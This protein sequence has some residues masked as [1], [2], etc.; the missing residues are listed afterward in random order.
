[1]LCFSKRTLIAG[2]LLLCGSAYAQNYA[3]LD[4]DNQTAGGPQVYGDFPKIVASETQSDSGT[5]EQWSKYDVIGAKSGM[6]YKI[7]PAQ[8]I[9]P[10]LEYH[11]SF[12]P[13]AYLGYLSADPCDIAFGMPFNNTGDATNPG[14]CTVYAGHWLYKAGTRLS[15]SIS[16]T[17]TTLYVAD[18]RNL[19]AGGYAVIYSG[20]P[21]AFV[22]AEHVLIQSVDRSVTPNRVVLAQRGYK[23][24]A[25]AHAANAIIAEHERG[26]G[27][28]NRN[29]AYN[30]STTGPRDANGRT[31]AQVMA[32]WIPGNMN[33][34]SKGQV[35]DVNVTGVY[36]DEDSYVMVNYQADAN[37]DLIIDNGILAN[38]RNVWGEGLDNFYALLRAR[39]PG[40]RIVAGW[41]QSRGFGS[42]NGT[43]MENWL[44]AGNDFAV[45]P[46]YTGNGGIYSQL[47]NYMIHLEHHTE[48]E[49]YTE[50]LSKVPT[51]L[52]PG[53]V[54]SGPNPVVP[55]SNANFRLGFGA[56]L[57][58]N[59]HYGRQNSDWHPD[60]WYDEYAVNVVKGSAAYGRAIASNPN[61]E[62]AIRRHKGWLGRPLGERRRIYNADQFK[63]ERNLLNNG[64]FEGGTNGWQFNNVGGYIDSGTR[65]A[66]S[67][68]LRTTGHLAYAEDVGGASLRGPAIDLVAGRTYTLVFS[69]KAEQMRQM[70]V[71][72]DWSEHQGD[73]LVPTRW[74]RFVW[75][76]TA[77]SSGSFRPVFNLGRES[78]D[79]WF[80]EVYVFEGDP[81][82]FRRDFENGIVVV[83]ATPGT[84]TVNLGG[85]FQRIR[86]TGQDPINNGASL[87]S[88]TIPAWDAAILVRPDGNTAP[89][90]EPPPEPTPPPGDGVGIGNVAVGGRVWLDTDGD[91]I[92]EDDELSH[93]GHTVRLTDCSDRL[94]ASQVT[95][96]DGRYEFADIAAGKYRIATTAPS[97]TTFS[98]YFEGNYG[99]LDSN[100]SEWPGTTA[101]MNLLDGNRRLA[102]DIGLMP[103]QSASPSD[104]TA[105]AAASIGDW[106]WRDSNRD[107]IQSD[108]EP[109]WGGIRVQLQNCEGSVVQS[110]TTD[111][112]GFYTFK[113]ASGNYNLQFFNPS[114]TNFSPPLQGA[115][116]AKDSNVAQ[117]TGESGCLTISDGDDRQ[118]FDV[119]IMP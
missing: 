65:V 12:H 111:S 17:Q 71:R 56:A 43:Q 103:V 99:N 84:K 25:R 45:N 13:R 109:G 82:V 39:L 59:G 52:Y 91:G 29:W 118:W 51:R 22:N 88:V 28:S 42:L 18:A 108:G 115:S 2:V 86:G 73:Y 119:G 94:L 21:G 6:L 100:I 104:V 16:N 102:V 46:D 69:A 92:Q 55:S 68:S 14:S 48:A 49:G 78:T 44:L 1:M 62:S 76:M 105:P 31:I 9:N 47:H 75:T 77:R 53:T 5:V 90:P 67:Q 38:G 63:P 87:S 106:V 110:T 72:L 4:D 117:A 54:K 113:V 89:A 33:R 23:S 50:A 81:N 24:V 11:Y 114:G 32:S 97:G 61:D 27:G 37:N 85:T 95:D 93:R 15:Y 66:G 112:A 96:A 19:A 20:G 34:N 40:K 79:V 70:Y 64:G 57:L 116:R 83:N 3:Y 8:K 36:F 101:C 60:P 41:R 35:M 7:A 74:T 10:A 58:G 30:I 107:G 26:S 98:P 80:D